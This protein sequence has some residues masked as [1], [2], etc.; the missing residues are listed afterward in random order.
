M[1][2]YVIRHGRPEVAPG[3]CYGSTDLVVSEHEQA[4]VLQ[5]LAP[6]LPHKAPVFSSPLRR[7]SALAARLAPSVGCAAVEHDG[8]LAEIHFGAWEM[9]AWDT[10]PQTEIEAWANDLVGFRPGGGESVLEVAQRVRAFHRDL[11]ERQLAAAIVVCH[12]GTL[13][14][15]MKCTAGETPFAMA[16]A[17]ASAPHQI[18]YGELVILDC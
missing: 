6:K 9:R 8:R 17:A 16:K 4:R 10:I 2:L 18:A 15:L 7:C 3:L 13:R 5:D 1:R 12:A 14:L 11:Q